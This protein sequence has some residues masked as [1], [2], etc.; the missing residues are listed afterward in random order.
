MASAISSAARSDLPP[1]ALARTGQ[2]FVL[3][4]TVAVTAAMFACLSIGFYLS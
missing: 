3:P 2:D 1:V 4:F